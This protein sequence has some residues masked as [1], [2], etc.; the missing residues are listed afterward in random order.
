MQIVHLPPWVYL[1]HNY[2]MPKMKPGPKTH[3]KFLCDCGMRLSASE[4]RRH[5]CDKDVLEARAIQRSGGGKYP[6]LMQLGVSGKPFPVAVVIDSTERGYYTGGVDDP[7]LEIIVPRSQGGRFNDYMEAHRSVTGV[8]ELPSSRDGD[9]IRGIEINCCH[10]KSL[11]SDGDEA[12]PVVRV[13]MIG[14]VS[15]YMG[16]PTRLSGKIRHL[17]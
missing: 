6:G 10:I 17:R 12:L 7:D 3:R 15:H 5:S 8:I 9:M 2:G 16:G 1:C 13:G 11:S 14:G 4:V